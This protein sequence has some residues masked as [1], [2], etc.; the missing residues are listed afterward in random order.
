[1]RKKASICETYP[2]TVP[3]ELETPQ[4]ASE[5]VEACDL[6]DPVLDEVDGLES[7]EVLEGVG[8]GFEVVEGEVERATKEHKELLD[9]R[10]RFQNQ[11]EE[12]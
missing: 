4:S 9:S 3:T 7:G 11:E 12:K 8:D 2:D 5:G 6:G 1:L 10:F